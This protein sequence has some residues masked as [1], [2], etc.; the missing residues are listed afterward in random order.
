MVWESRLDMTSSLGTRPTLLPS[1]HVRHALTGVVVCLA[2]KLVMLVM[3]H[4]SRT[5]CGMWCVEDRLRSQV[6]RGRGELLGTTGE[7]GEHVRGR[8]RA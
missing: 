3:R 7:G 5:G 6:R 8:N 4:E 1:S 2:V